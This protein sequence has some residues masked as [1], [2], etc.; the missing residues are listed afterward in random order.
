MLRVSELGEGWFDGALC[1]WQ[2]FGLGDS[3]ENRRLLTDFRGVLRPG[4]RL[5]M[6]IYNAEAVN[7]LPEESI[8]ERSGRLVRTRR[9]RSGGRLRVEIEYAGSE[10]RDVHDW[11]I[12][13]PSAFEKLANEAGL[14]VLL[15]CA[16][17]DATI[18]PSDDHLRM[19][20]LLERR[21]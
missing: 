4:G 14:E 20:F 13:S 21:A 3:V 6:D 12:Y 7:Q 10:V 15:S 19:Q 11:E 5:L 18:P 9:T 17:F 1:L 2:S 16:W 8:E